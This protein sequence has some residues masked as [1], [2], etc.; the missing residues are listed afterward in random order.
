MAPSPRRWTP[1]RI[2][3]P[4]GW[5]ASWSA[6]KKLR[7]I[8]WLPG[9]L[10]GARRDGGLILFSLFILVLMLIVGGVAVDV[11][12][13]ETERTMLQNTLDSATLAAT[14]INRDDID[15]EQMVKGLPWRRWV[16]TP[17]S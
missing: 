2:R 11:M 7:Q 5:L 4:D 8:A 15:P 6:R 17:T 12:R 16:T 3:R 13:F 1:W 10:T 9:S 14:N